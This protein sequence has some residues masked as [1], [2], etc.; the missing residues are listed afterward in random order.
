MSLV[1]QERAEGVL[2]DLLK[3]EGGMS[4]R[5]LDFIDDMDKKRNLT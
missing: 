1:E 3:C 4:G 2:D 5:E